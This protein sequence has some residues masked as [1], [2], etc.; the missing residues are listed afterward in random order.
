VLGVG[1]WVLGLG[2]DIITSM[3]LTQLGSILI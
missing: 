3:A 1:C 2:F